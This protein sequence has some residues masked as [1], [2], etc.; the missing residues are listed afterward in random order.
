MVWKVKDETLGVASGDGRTW[1]PWFENLFWRLGVGFRTGTRFGTGCDVGSLC[2]CKVMKEQKGMGNVESEEH[3]TNKVIR[4]SRRHVH[5][6]FK[7][8]SDVDMEWGGHVSTM[9]TN[10]FTKKHVGET[11]DACRRRKMQWWTEHKNI[12]KRCVTR[13]KAESNSSIRTALMG[14]CRR[15][16]S[17]NGRG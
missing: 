1:N 16:D 10:E 12:V 13:R 15:C 9:V 7:F 11:D 4:W 2:M 3:L 6:C 14:K 17:Q 8:A 5:K